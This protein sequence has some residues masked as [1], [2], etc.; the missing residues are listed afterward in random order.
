MYKVDYG[1]M[2]ETVREK[3]KEP[4]KWEYYDPSAISVY[5]CAICGAKLYL[6]ELKESCPICG[7]ETCAISKRGYA[8]GERVNDP[9]Y[10]YDLDGGEF[11]CGGC[12]ESF[13]QR[14][15]S[16]IIVDYRE[17][18]AKRYKVKYIETVIE[19]FGE[20][21]SDFERVEDGVLELVEKIVKGSK[22][23]HHDKWRF[24]KVG[25]KEANGL[26]KV[27]EGWHS[28]MGAS[29]LS[30]KINEITDGSAMEIDFPVAVLFSINSNV[31]SQP[32]SVYAPPFKKSEIREIL[33][34][35]AQPSYAGL[36]AV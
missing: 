5:K 3:A 28:S 20:F 24:T 12:S 6:A 2:P 23:I 25:G 13:R 7:G 10:L 31:C 36:R 27:L 1:E 11:I 15:N 32:I 26:V 21:R 8:H 29:P 33:D 35:R 34:K 19:D 30:K 14:A 4:E 16:L 17:R 22:T 18:P 9:Y